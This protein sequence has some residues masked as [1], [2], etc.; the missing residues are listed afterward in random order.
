MNN[1]IILIRH[2]QSTANV[3]AK[4]YYGPDE[5]IV[6]T[7]K[8]IYQSKVL[9]RTLH[10]T[11][12]SLMLNDEVTVIAS[13][14]TRAQL[15]AKH[16][17]QRFKHVNIKHDH[18]ISE[19]ECDRDDGAQIESSRDVLARVKSLIDDHPNGSL[20]L[21]THGWLMRIV[22]PISGSAKNTEYRIYDRRRFQH[23]FM[24][25]VLLK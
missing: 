7:P 3:D 13:G 4:L 6:L 18:R 15:T 24:D 2:G 14:M 21:F 25:R 23:V 17:L 19:C 5:N 10:Q 22:D 12:Q 1:K 9:G 11:F 16:A 8:G 20:I